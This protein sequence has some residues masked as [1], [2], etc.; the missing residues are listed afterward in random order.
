MS[1]ISI[2]IYI[3]IYDNPIYCNGINS[4]GKREK[5]YQMSAGEGYCN[6]FYPYLDCLDFDFETERYKKKEQCLKAY[7]RHNEND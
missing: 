1:Q 3:D 6:A 2:K 5:C 4:A 7:R